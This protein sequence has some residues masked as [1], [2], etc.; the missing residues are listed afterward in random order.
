MRTDGA[1]IIDYRVSY[2]QSTGIYVV[3]ASGLTSRSYTRTVPLTPGAS[4]NFKVEARNSVGYSNISTARS[5]IASQIPD[6]P[7][8]PVTE[9]FESS[10]IVTWTA[11]EFN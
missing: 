3:L 6:K 5:I 9:R 1:P 10:I 7:N 4:Y 11:L 2:D 8:T